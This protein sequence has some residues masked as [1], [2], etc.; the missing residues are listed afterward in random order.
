MKL[1]LASAALPTLLT[2][3]VLVG[4]AKRADIVFTPRQRFAMC[5][6]VINGNPSNFFLMP[7][8]DKNGKARFAKAFNAKPTTAFSGPGTRSLAKPSFPHQSG[9]IQRMLDAAT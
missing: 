8:K 9:F 3:C 5:I 7:Y 6:H 1:E 4:H 2:D